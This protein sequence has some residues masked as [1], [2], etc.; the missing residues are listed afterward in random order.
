MF[1][2]LYYGTK[3]VLRMIAFLL[4]R[5]FVTEGE[6]AHPASVGYR[7]WVSLAGKVLAFRK[8]D[9]SLKFYW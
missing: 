7:S 6:Y 3:A 1:T 4:L 2:R 8:L 9:G 5:M